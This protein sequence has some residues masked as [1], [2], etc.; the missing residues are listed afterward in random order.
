MNCL[1]RSGLF[2][3]SHR[4][5]RSEWDGKSID[6]V[7]RSSNGLNTLYS[8]VNRIVIEKGSCNDLRCD[9]ITSNY[10]LLRSF[11][12]ESG[13]LRNLSSLRIDNNPHLE[14][15]TV[16]GSAFENVKTVII[17]SIVMID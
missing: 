10:P 11:V 14:S 8:F 5:K 7:V 16:G 9:L 13:G 1:E 12:V 17:E 6:A 2:G 4:I 15:I 3:Y